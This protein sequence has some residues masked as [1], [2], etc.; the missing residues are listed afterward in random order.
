MLILG[1]KELEDG[2]VSVRSRK[3]GATEVMSVAELQAKLVM[4]IATKAQ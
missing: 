3:T 2:T 1:D 4:E